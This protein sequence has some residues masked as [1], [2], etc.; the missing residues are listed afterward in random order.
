MSRAL[1]VR[2]IQRQ[3]F[4][5]RSTCPN[6]ST[7]APLANALER[8]R[9]T[10]Q[11]SDS[12][13][14]EVDGAQ[15]AFPWMNHLTQNCHHAQ[16]VRQTRWRKLFCSR[17]MYD[18]IIATHGEMIHNNHDNDLKKSVLANLMKLCRITWT[19][20]QPETAS[21]RELSQPSRSRNLK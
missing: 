13:T 15:Q 9:G 7:A 5:A 14:W 21:E 17:R 19:L 18:T 1:L 4:D 12:M 20:N 2:L 10:T 6:H 11:R 3:L 8:P 16:E